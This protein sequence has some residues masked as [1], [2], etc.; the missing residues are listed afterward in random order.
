[1]SH[2]DLSRLSPRLRFTTPAALVIRVSWLGG[3]PFEVRIPAFAGETAATLA[4]KRHDLH[5]RAV[6]AASRMTGRAMRPADCTS[7][8][9][10]PEI[11]RD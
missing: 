3:A 11:G 5:R 10:R 7:T 4:R 1:M 9:I 6:A 8:F 2:T